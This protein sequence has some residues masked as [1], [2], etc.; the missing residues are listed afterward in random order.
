MASS[1]LRFN[2]NLPYLRKLFHDT[3]SE[4]NVPLGVFMAAAQ[5][6]VIRQFL[7]QSLETRIAVAKGALENPSATQGEEGVP[8]EGQGK[9]W[10]VERVVWN[11]VTTSVDSL[12]DGARNGEHYFIPGLN[13]VADSFHVRYTMNI[14]S[15][16]DKVREA[17]QKKKK[18]FEEEEEQK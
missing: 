14:T 7:G 11:R 10:H 5:P 3:A 12:H 18:M 17:L 13:H 16:F 8:R 6:A 15:I 4:F 9:R 1:K 2:C